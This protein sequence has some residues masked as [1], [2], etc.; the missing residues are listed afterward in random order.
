MVTHVE[1][2]AVGLVRHGEAGQLSQSDLVGDGLVHSAQD[3][4]LSGGGDEGHDLW[5][6]GA[7]RPTLTKCLWKHHV[8]EDSGRRGLPSSGRPSSG[9][10]SLGSGGRDGGGVRAG[11]RDGRSSA[12]RRLA[13]MSWSLERFGPAA[14]ERGVSGGEE[15]ESMR[16]R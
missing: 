16:G 12:S 6:G 4:G 1:G 14:G 2:Q 7:E 11:C 5:G 10:L 15:V 3:E 9:S 8:R 13:N